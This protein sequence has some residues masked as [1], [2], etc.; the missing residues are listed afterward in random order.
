MCHQSH[1]NEE[2]T[3]EKITLTDADGIW[4]LDLGDEMTDTF[5]TVDEAL[6]AIATEIVA[7]GAMSRSQSRYPEH[8]YP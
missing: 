4:I 5:D 1:E 6:A 7:G 3:M 8:R 2:T